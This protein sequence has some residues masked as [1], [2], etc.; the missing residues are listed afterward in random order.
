MEEQTKTPDTQTGGEQTPPAGNQGEELK[1]FTQKQI[2][3]MIIAA[4]QQV[5]KKFADYDE[6]K[7]K[8]EELEKAQKEAKLAEMD[9]LERTKTSLAEK[10]EELT[11]LQTQIAEME[12]SQKR[13]AVTNAFKEAAISANIPTK[14]LEDAKVLAGISEETDVEKIEELVKKLVEE[15][16]FLVETK[17]PQQKQI[18]DHSNGATKVNEKTKSE[19][20]TEAADKARRTQRMEDKLA[21]VNLK[22]KLGM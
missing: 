13:T 19:M 9:E 12:L 20:L 22:A 1:Q 5:K 2:D 10:D 14:R 4:K 7:A 15:K 8:A 6:V 21:Y 3:E 17:A 11:K 16:P 18:G